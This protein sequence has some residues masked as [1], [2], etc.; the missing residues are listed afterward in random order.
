MIKQP[1]AK[2]GTSGIVSWRPHLTLPINNKIKANAPPIIMPMYKDARINFRPR[3]APMPPMNEASPQPIPPRDKNI[4]SAKIPQPAAAPSMPSKIASVPPAILIKRP[5]TPGAIA[6]TS[7]TSPLSK[8]VNEFTTRP[9]EPTPTRRHAHEK[10][11]L[12]K[13]NTAIA[14]QIISIKIYLTEI[15]APQFLHLPLSINHEKTG[16]NSKNPKTW[17]QFSQTERSLPH[18]ERLLTL[19]WATTFKKEPK[20]APKIPAIIKK[21][22][23]IFFIFIF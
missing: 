17:P 16:I 3:T 21:Y 23:C 6:K 14:A 8:S 19:L 4:I 13:I 5:R 20:Q 12:L 15:F 1:D 7:K 22:S 2:K 10:L 11:Y 18:H 9:Q